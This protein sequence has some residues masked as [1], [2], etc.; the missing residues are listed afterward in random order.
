MKLLYSIF[1]SMVIMSLASCGGSDTSRGSESEEGHHHHSDEEVTEV[2]VTEEQLKTVGIELGSIQYKEL[3]DVIHANGRL[4]VNPQD[5]ADVAPLSAGIVKRIMVVEGQRVKAGQPVAYQENTE[6]LQVQQDYLTALDE[7]KLAQ[8]EYDRQQALA[9]QGAGVKKNLQQAT[10]MLGIAEARRDALRGRLAQLGINAASVSPSSLHSQVPVLAPISG[11]VAKVNAR[12]GSYADMSSPLMTI[13]DNSGVFALLQVYEKDLS[14]IK[15]GQIVELR[16]TNNPSVTMEG[17]ISDI[18]RAIDP[19]TKTIN[20]RV[21]IDSPDK[22]ALIPGMGVTALISTGESS[23]MAIP[24][25][26]IASIDGKSF[27]F[28]LE[29]VHEEEGGKAYHFKLVP[30]VTGAREMGFT[31]ITLEQPLSEDATV[32]VGNAFYLTSMAADHGEHNH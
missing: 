9:S 26:A 20:V 1:S 4:S 14:L 11:I 24:D 19:V 32:V 31:Q 12:T 13:V 21:A 28:V 5:E 17:K 3:G 7:A 25:E 15:M 10:A 27:I 23:V 8:Q 29:D 2:E 30:V 18:T 22:D 16:M 6:V